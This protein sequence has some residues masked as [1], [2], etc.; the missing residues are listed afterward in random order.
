ML[1]EFRHMT[2]IKRFSPLELS[3]GRKSKLNFN[4]ETTGLTV[5]IGELKIW[6]GKYLALLLFKTE[7][8]GERKI[9]IIVA[10]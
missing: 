5:G 4:F 3:N 10:L 8:K 9:M 1:I 7:A 2:S 6:H